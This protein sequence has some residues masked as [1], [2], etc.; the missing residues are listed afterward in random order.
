MKKSEVKKIYD[1]FF[2]LSG[3]V[4]AANRYVALE[5]K[6]FK[7]EEAELQRIIKQ[8]VEGVDSAFHEINRYVMGWLLKLK[9]DAEED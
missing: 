4:Y 2:Q 8:R 6:G 3:R 5:R 9:D 7:P 1:E